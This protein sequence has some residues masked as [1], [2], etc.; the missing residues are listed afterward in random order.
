[1]N[2]IAELIRVNSFS[3]L[4]EGDKI[5]SIKRTGEFEI[6]EFVKTLDAPV[7]E[8]SI[9]INMSKDGIPK[10]YEGRLK[11]VY[12]G[13]LKDEKWYRYEDNAITW[14]HMYSAQAKFHEAEAKQCKELAELKKNVIEEKEEE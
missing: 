5:W 1:M 6:L 11:D 8:Y 2:T 9:F 12:E 7:E 13:R 4:K 3:E 14:Y 10:F